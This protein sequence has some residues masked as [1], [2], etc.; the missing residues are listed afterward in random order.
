MQNLRKN[1]TPFPVPSFSRT[2]HNITL[3]TFYKAC[4]IVKKKL[5]NIPIRLYSFLG[6]YIISTDDLYN[7]IYE[8]LILVQ[9]Q[10]ANSNANVS[11]RYVHLCVFI[12]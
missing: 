5:S 3:T 8:D 12:F 4:E 11:S 9:N 6:K 2:L 7:Y 1:A 10:F